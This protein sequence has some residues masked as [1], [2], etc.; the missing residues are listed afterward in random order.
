MNQNVMTLIIVVGVLVI[1]SGIVEIAKKLK[2]KKID[3]ESMLK[4]ADTGLGY[5]QSVAEAVK[6]FLPKI[7]GEIITKTLTA[8]QKAVVRAEATYK[9]ANSTD[10][11]AAD[12]RRTEATSLVKSALALDGIQDTPDVDKLINAVIPVLVLALPK[13]HTDTA[14]TSAA[15]TS[16]PMKVG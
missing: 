8:A 9:A 14:G 13:T 10:T 4:T 2:E 12:N 15:A 7:A 16:T 6:P 3:T 11:K 1:Y 5:A